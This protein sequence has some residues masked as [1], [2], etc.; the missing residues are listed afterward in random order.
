MAMVRIFR[1][2]PRSF[3]FAFSVAAALAFSGVLLVNPEQV[4]WPV[5]LFM[6]AIGLLW[7][8]IAFSH[9]RTRYLVDAEGITL[10]SLFLRRRAR[11]DD[12]VEAEWGARLWALA[13]LPEHLILTLAAGGGPGERV[14]FTVFGDLDDWKGMLAE[15][16]KH[17]GP[18]GLM[19]RRP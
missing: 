9:V 3:R 14:R 10:E 1:T 16:E 19:P 11:W 2:S 18:R 12:V 7:G 5:K 13:Y 8:L 15:L 4:P 17:L 6:A